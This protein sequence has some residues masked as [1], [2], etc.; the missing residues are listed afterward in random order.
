M[1]DEIRDVC[2]RWEVGMLTHWEAMA[3]IRRIVGGDSTELRTKLY[4]PNPKRLRVGETRAP[5]EK[6]GNRK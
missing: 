6:R 4:G 1:Q 3:A 5:K 2:D